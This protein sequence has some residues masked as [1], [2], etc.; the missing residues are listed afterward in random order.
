MG[1]YSG[2]MFVNE[3]SLVIETSYNS[4]YGKGNRK[5]L[6]T[7]T[8]YGSIFNTYSS[9]QTGQVLIDGAIAG[10]SGYLTGSVVNCWMKFT[11]AEAKLI[12]EA[13]LRQ[14]TIDT[15]GTWQFQGSNDDSSYENIGSTFLLGGGGSHISVIN[16]ISENRKSFKYYRIIGISGDASGG[17][18]LME[19]EFKTN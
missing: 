7:Y 9:L 10:S 4:A 1:Y 8:Q 19:I 18:Y 17:P 16:S 5:S 3:T 2:K 11:L 15:H 6:I 13:T 12:N 14:N